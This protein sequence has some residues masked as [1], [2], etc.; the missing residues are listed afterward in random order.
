MFI[1]LMSSV[2][3]CSPHKVQQYIPSHSQV[4]PPESPHFT[5]IQPGFICYIS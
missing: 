3:T 5:L 1:Y 4:T 2:L